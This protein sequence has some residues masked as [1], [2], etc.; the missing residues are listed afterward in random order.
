M[1]VYTGHTW[2]TLTRA[3][4]EALAGYAP[5]AYGRV[6]LEAV[7]GTEYAITLRRESVVTGIDHLGIR[8]ASPPANDAFAAATAVVGSAWTGL[9]SN[10]DATSEPSE[11][12][13]SLSDVPSGASVWWRWIAPLTACIGFPPRAAASTPCWWC[14]PARAWVP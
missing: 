7:A 12:F 14:T 3:G 9:G 10:V 1:T 6:F 4:T 2:P 5:N 11:P 13:T 8:P